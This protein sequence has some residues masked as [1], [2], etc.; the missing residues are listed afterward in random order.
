MTQAPGLRE[1]KKEATRRALT[2][3]AMRMAVER[4]WDAVRVEDI[5]AEV[6]VSTRTFNNYFA[7]KEEAVIAGSFDRAERA[8]AALAARPAGEPLWEAVTNA[9][10]GIMAAEEHEIGPVAAAHIKLVMGHPALA[11]QQLR[12]E[13]EAV[14]TLS[15]AIGERVG[16]DPDTDPFPRLAAAVALAATRSAVEHWAGR[17]PGTPMAEAVRAAL[18][19]VT[20]DPAGPRNSR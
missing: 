14:A 7:S 17:R 19:R 8:R 20:I 16:T 10:A 4:G 12:F 15:T 9:L 5:A 1:R 3:T 18:S 11:A 6:G 2:R 13:R